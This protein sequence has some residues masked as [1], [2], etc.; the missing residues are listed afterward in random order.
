M[1]DALTKDVRATANPVKV[2]KKVSFGGTVVEMGTG[3]GDAARW[4]KKADA[5]FRLDSLQ[6]EA[7]NHVSTAMSSF[8]QRTSIVKEVCTPSSP[9]AIWRIFVDDLLWC[10]KRNY[11]KFCT[12]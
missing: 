10:S 8:V 2:P 6:E 5:L 11:F 1:A 4:K 12:E 9:R 3:T 7:S